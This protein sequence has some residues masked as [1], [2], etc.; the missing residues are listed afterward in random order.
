MSLTGSISKTKSCRARFGTTRLASAADTWH[1][2]RR[3]WIGY[4]RDSS[5]GLARTGFSRSQPSGS[6]R[7]R[8]LCAVIAHLYI[9]WIHPFGDGNGRTARLV[10]VWTLLAAGF[11]MPASHLLS[12]HYNETR[13]EY[14]RQLDYASRSGG[15]ILPFLRY[16]VTGFVDS[17]RGQLEVIFQQQW[18]DRW[19]Q[20]IYEQ[21]GGMSTPARV[22]QRELALELSKHPDPVRRVDIPGLSVL[23]NQA[24][25]GTTRTLARDLNALVELGL[26]ERTPRGYRTRPEVL[27]AFLPYRATVDD[28]DTGLFAPVE[29]PGA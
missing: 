23:L 10:E 19:E 5:N 11:P 26:L 24:Y 29:L 28:F 7:L 14:D 16:A 1:L 12:N 20:Y 25:H 21:F 22:R 6:S 8:A 13:A 15:D 2:P 4:S 17:I 9:A 27:V 18:A 3:R